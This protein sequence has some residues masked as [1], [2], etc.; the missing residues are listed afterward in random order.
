MFIIR[1]SY[2]TSL[3]KVSKRPKSSRVS[4]KFKKFAKKMKKIKSMNLKQRYKKILLKKQF[5]INKPRNQVAMK[6]MVKLN[7]LRIKLAIIKTLKVRNGHKV[8]EIMKK[9]TIKI[10]KEDNLIRSGNLRKM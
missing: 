2:L 5:R 8:K 1:P 3:F 10:M 9:K 7:I 4:I 6:E